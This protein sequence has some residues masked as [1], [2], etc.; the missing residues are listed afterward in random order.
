M[1]STLEDDPIVVSLLPGYFKN[2]SSLLTQMNHAFESGDIKNLGRLA[3]TVKGSSACYGFEKI[4]DEASRLESECLSS[5]SESSHLA[6]HI[7]QLTDL[8]NMAL[9]AHSPQ[10]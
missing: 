4:A 9:S 8:A 1:K 10:H 5:S 2:L 6:A 7:S 3:H